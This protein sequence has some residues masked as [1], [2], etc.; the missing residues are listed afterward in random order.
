MN[1]QAKLS[2]HLA[3]RTA[4]AAEQEEDTLHKGL[5]TNSASGTCESREKESGLASESGP[6]E[7]FENYISMD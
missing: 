7:H 6:C 3:S 4:L 5:T 2:E 1:K